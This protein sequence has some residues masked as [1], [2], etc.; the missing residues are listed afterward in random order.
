MN[1]MPIAGESCPICKQARL[2]NAQQNCTDYIT[3]Q[4]FELLNCPHCGCYMTVGDMQQDYYGQTYYNSKKGKFNPIIE[5]IFKLNHQ[6]N[7]KQ[8]YQR[9]QPQRIL[10][11]GCGRAYLLK[12][13]RQIGCKV[14]CLESSEAAEWILNNPDVNVVTE[15]KLDFPAQY[16]DL[17]IYWHVFE[18]L[19]DPVASLRQVGAVLADNQRLC[20]S[21]PNVDSYQAKLNLS[22]WFHLDVP[23]HLYH[24]TPQGLVMLLESEGYE[25]ESIEAGDAIQ[26]LYGWLQ[27]LANWFTPKEI[28][29]FYRFLQGGAPLK[30]LSKSAL[31]IQL[32]T[33]IFWIPVGIIAYLIE[34]F[35]GKH[36]SITVYARKKQ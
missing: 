5:K 1:T 29:G 27:S 2:I 22:T 12:E 36:G 35:S 13:L 4:T 31:L 19:S 14:Y 33:S 10:E 20:I 3:K 18:H 7:A 32:V 26:N 30:T 24:F 21:V 34:T 11:I 9:F 8:F 16:F 6:R 25:V 17:I 28:N 15:N 23:R